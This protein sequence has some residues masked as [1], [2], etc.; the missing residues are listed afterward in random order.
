MKN[1]FIDA[2]CHL[3]FEDYDNDRASVYKHA[4]EEGVKLIN[5]GTNN[6]TSKKAIELFKEFGSKAIVGIH[7]IEV[8]ADS[9]L[10]LISELV[11]EKGVVGIGECGLDYFRTDSNFWNKQEE[12]FRAQIA[13]AKKTCLPLMLHIRN[14]K[15]D[16]TK[17]A[18]KRVI[19]ILREE[20]FTLGGEAHFF[21]GTIDDA[22]A[23]LDLG[24]HISFTGVITFVKD[25][26]ELVR[27][28]PMDR[29][30]SET[31][32]PYVSPVPHRGERNEPAHVIQVARRIAEIKGME[33]N[34]VK[35]EI[36]RNVS[37]LFGSFE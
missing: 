14:S 25:Y 16:K 8:N 35:S 13:L 18:Y 29:I 27:F 5:V 26:D 36:Y 1:Y 9:N 32:S 20:N 11:K 30:I 31:D 15:E 17:D 34:E 33:L 12:I 21:A 2:H 23:F 19:E 10:D 37:K 28:V 3:N 22:K 4:E 24:F 7:P 6:E